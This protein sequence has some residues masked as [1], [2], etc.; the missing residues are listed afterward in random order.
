MCAQIIADAAHRRGCRRFWADG[1]QTGNYPETGLE[2]IN[3]YVLET[4]FWTASLRIVLDVTS[5]T[6]YV[7]SANAY[8]QL[9]PKLRS[10]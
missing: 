2:E 5:G 7:V 4:D 9:N 10:S 8:R 6:A 3:G 1:R